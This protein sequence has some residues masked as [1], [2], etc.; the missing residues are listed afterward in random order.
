MVQ[1]FTEVI[2][3]KSKILTLNPSK[4]SSSF[5]SQQ[6]EKHLAE[7]EEREEPPPQA[8]LSGQFLLDDSKFHLPLTCASV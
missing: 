7:K 4:H 6:P 8:S 5:T 2:I 3:C 1:I